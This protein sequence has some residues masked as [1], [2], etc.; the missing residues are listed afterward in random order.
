[1]HVLRTLDDCRALAAATAG[2]DTRVVVVGAGFIGAEVAATCHG[3]GLAVTVVEAL[4]VPL[5]GALGEAMG[6]A[7]GALH[8]R[9]GVRLRTG[10]GVAGLETTGE[11]GQRRV[12]AVEL[13]DGSTEPADVV[14][15]GIGVTPVTDWLEGSGLE[16]RNGVVTDAQLF[17]ADSVV[18]AGD[19]ARWCDPDGTEHRFEHWT[20]AA[21]QGPHAARSLLAGRGG[22]HAY[23]P[24]PYFWSDQYD[25]KIQMLGEP[26]PDDDVA[27]V[28]G[29][30]EEGRFVAIY[31]RSG[32]LTAALGFGRPRQLMGYR[33][34]L[35]AGA[36]FGEARAHTP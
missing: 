27:V 3:R 16:V 34:L 18:V 22:A 20:N 14:L 17:A 5:A 33:A 6:A 35:E 32:R 11:G 8:E 30:V 29:S 25:V 26:R 24:V 2:P 12:S 28:D 19:A 15:V 21:E 13:A 10:V 1:V 31:G 36:G 7:C 4:P 23:L 9:N